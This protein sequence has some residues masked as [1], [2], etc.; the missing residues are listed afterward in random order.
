M[1]V[2]ALEPQPPREEGPT[3]A[4][5]T[6][7]RSGFPLLNWIGT[8]STSR[9]IVSAIATV[10][11]PVAE[12]VTDPAAFWFAR[13]VVRQDDRPPSPSETPTSGVIWTWPML[14][15][16]GAGRIASSVSRSI[17]CS[18]R[19]HGRPV[20]TIL[21]GRCERLGQRP[22]TQLRL[23]FFASTKTTM[24]RS[25]V[26]RPRMD[27]LPIATPTTL[28][29]RRW[30]PRSRF[31]GRT[32]AAACSLLP[33]ERADLEEPRRTSRPPSAG[34]ANNH[35]RDEA[36]EDPIRSTRGVGLQK[37]IMLTPK[38]IAM[39]ARTRPLTLYRRTR[40]EEPTQTIPIR[41]GRAGD[42]HSV[43]SRMGEI[44][45]FRI[46]ESARFSLE[47]TTPLCGSPRK[48][49]LPGARCPAGF[50]WR[51]DRGPACGPRTP[52]RTPSG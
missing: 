43:P 14:T 5:R 30:L 46:K 18:D 7:D 44:R 12:S 17:A 45:G 6:C 20:S 25:S 40:T 35:V 34:D 27:L 8:K 36:D 49:Q 48:T 4:P 11:G 51:F 2:E 24:H 9:A 52:R 37:D 32:S 22:S 39:N 1:T 31:G 50:T 21:Y 15:P 23:G 42:I 38:T 19:R 26:S 47:I 13:R 28:A 10:G 29:G 33:L 16:P 41:R 3:A